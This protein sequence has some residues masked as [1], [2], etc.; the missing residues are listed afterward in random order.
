MAAVTAKTFP[1]IGTVIL[2]LTSPDGRI[3]MIRWLGGREA[4][5]DAPRDAGLRWLLAT[6]H[7]AVVW[8]RKDGER[9]LLS[10]GETLPA[11][12]LLDLRAFGPDGEVFVWRDASGLRGRQRVDG[13]G[14][15]VDTLE[16][17]QLLWG[18]EPDPDRKPYD[19]FFPLRDGD[20]G[21]RHAPPLELSE[22][23]FVRPADE[24]EKQDEFYG[25]RPARL[26]LRHYIGEDK[27]TGVARIVDTRLVAVEHA[28]PPAKKAEEVKEDVAKA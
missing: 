2:A 13:Q 26:R 11:A 21:L 18:T 4:D 8:G 17:V 27:D 12:S 9:W 24:G 7:D 3:D 28:M 15:E 16:E 22:S 10:A 14:Q 25:H 20:Q 5:Q 23:Y 1:K 19:G 6:T